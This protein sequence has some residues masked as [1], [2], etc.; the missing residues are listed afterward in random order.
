MKDVYN[1]IFERMEVRL[2][3]AEHDFL[4][5]AIKW[6][7]FS[8]IPVTL[9]FLAAVYSLQKPI[10]AGAILHGLHK[11][12]G[13]LFEGLERTRSPNIIMQSA[14]TDFD[15]TNSAINHSTEYIEKYE[16]RTNLEVNFNE[17][18]FMH[19]SLEDYL[20]NA[21]DLECRY[22]LKQAI[23]ESELDRFCI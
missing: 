3:K 14:P 1:T 15:P 10:S 2:R 13:S 4:L 16:D 11:L 5:T 20:R 17:L 6:V 7:L 18:R 9:E 21:D 22:A 12:L 8:R 19:G 23:A